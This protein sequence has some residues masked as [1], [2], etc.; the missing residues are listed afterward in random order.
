MQEP[1]GRLIFSEWTATMVVFL[2][3][4]LASAGVL[5][6]ILAFTPEVYRVQ[7]HSNHSAHVG[8][9]VLLPCLVVK[10]LKSRR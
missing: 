7:L 4:V 1:R 2:T 6:W 9:L 3:L 8:K 10:M 5:I